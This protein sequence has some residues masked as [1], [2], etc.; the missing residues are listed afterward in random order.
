M[1]MSK[2]AHAYIDGHIAT[3]VDELSQEDKERIAELV[4][5]RETLD[6]QF[7]AAFSRLQAEGVGAATAMRSRELSAFL[8]RQD[9]IDNEMK[10]SEPSPSEILCAT[11]A[12]VVAD[13]NE[14]GEYPMASYTVSIT[15]AGVD[16]KVSKMRASTKGNFTLV[17]NKEEI[18]S[19]EM[20]KELPS[21]MIEKFPDVFT[22]PRNEYA[23][24]VYYVMKGDGTETERIT[25]KTTTKD[26]G[27]AKM[28]K[29]LVTAKGYTDLVLWRGE[30][31]CLEVRPGE[32]GPVVQV[33]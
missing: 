26:C 14:N 15:D 3:V 2:A 27:L 12:K 13:M 23:D 22:K 19:A 18:A 7:E 17:A 4:Q 24:R 28:M 6:E 10:E 20:A 16:Y 5:E 25:Q 9:E 11:L 8:Q 32:G 1:P 21:D 30:R 31:I 29:E 33:G